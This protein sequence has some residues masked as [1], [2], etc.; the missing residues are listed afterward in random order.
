MKSMLDVCI[1]NVHKDG[2]W[3][4]LGGAMVYCKFFF[5]K[6]WLA[7]SANV[8]CSFYTRAL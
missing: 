1:K 5:E 7:A 3:V 6:V 8:L 2:W 4:T